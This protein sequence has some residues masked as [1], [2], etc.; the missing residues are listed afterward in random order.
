MLVPYAYSI[1]S[2]KIARLKWGVAEHML[3]RRGRP[4]IKVERCILKFFERWV[5]RLMKTRRETKADSNLRWSQDDLRRT[6]ESWYLWYKVIGLAQDVN[7]TRAIQWS[8]RT[9]LTRPRKPR[10]GERWK[11]RGLNRRRWQRSF[12]RGLCSLEQ[13]RDWTSPCKEARDSKQ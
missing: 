6:Q 10:K 4:K 12:R 3:A 2:S 9:S 7:K 11:P 5:M 1:T 8:L 13:Q